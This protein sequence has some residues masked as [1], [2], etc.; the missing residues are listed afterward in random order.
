M[1]MIKSVPVICLFLIILSEFSLAQLKVDWG[2]KL[3]FGEDSLVE[4]LKASDIDYALVTWSNSNWLTAR[5]DF[6]CMIQQKGKW[7]LAKLGTNDRQY[8][9]G[10][11]VVYVVQKQL[12][13][14]E[15]TSWLKSI[16][17]DRAFSVTQDNLNK[18]PETCSY[19]TKEGVQFRVGGISDAPTTRLLLYKKGIVQSLKF[20]GVDFYLRKCY[21]HA[22]EYG[23]LKG[24]ALSSY[25]L[26]KMVSA[27]D[28]R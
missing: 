20:Y 8:V 23:I 26:S 28:L 4:L 13:D 6:S 2:R 3:S 12:T 14:E 10:L 15:G 17:P 22:S 1:K 9:A 19:T 24:L 11:D 27:V 16:D 5:Q 25:Q 18:L 7:Y 21:P